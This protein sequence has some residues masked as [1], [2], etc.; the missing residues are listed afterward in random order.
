[1]K[2]FLFLAIVLS[3]FSGCVSQK[4]FRYNPNAKSVDETLI[5]ASV[6]V[7]PF[8]DKRANDNTDS[9]GISLLPL[10]VWSSQNFDIPEAAKWQAHESQ[11]WFL[12]GHSV[13]EHHGESSKVISK[14][15]PREDI[16]KATA[17]ELEASSVFSKVYYG[18]TA[19]GS[20]LILQGVI[21]STNYYGMFYT[22]GVSVLSPVF[23][24]IGAPVTVNN[25]TLDITFILKNKSGS[26]LWE[27]NYRKKGSTFSSVYYIKEDFDFYELLKDMLLEVC[28][29]IRTDLSHIDASASQIQP[30]DKGNN[31]DDEASPI[32]EEPNEDL[33]LEDV[34]RDLNAT[35]EEK[36]ALG[37]ILNGLD[38]EE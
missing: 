25:N 8:A 1:M 6:V 36:E 21:N 4:V 26:V 37:D 34:L 29:D 27:K 38:S 16:A 23:W 2:K 10:V 31:F 15:N 20:D 12:L 11:W 33:N 19:K 5:H 13:A 14:W 28:E 18:K 7:P 9:R 24:A 32:S 30:G 17:E 3:I 22:Y 35:D